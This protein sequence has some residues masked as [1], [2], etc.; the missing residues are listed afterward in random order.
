MVQVLNCAIRIKIVIFALRRTLFNNKNMY[1]G[2]FID[3]LSVNDARIVR[4]TGKNTK[5]KIK[6]KNRYCN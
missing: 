2:Y 4:F 1:T 5:N 6:F 3:A